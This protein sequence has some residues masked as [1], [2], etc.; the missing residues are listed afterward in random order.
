[1][2]EETKRRT[3]SSCSSSSS[4]CLSFAS[5]SFS[6]LFFSSCVR[7]G[8]SGLRQ[9]RLQRKG[10]APT[11]SL[12]SCLCRG[13]LGGP[14]AAHGLRCGLSCPRKRSSTSCKTCKSSPMSPH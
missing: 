4:S 10:T 12:Y 2:R 3:F 5:Y 8:Q 11:R 13:A 9:R 6:F 7:V 1:M 14:P